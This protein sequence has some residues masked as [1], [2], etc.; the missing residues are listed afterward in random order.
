MSINDQEFQ[1]RFEGLSVAEAGRKVKELRSDGAV[2]DVVP[3]TRTRVVP[4]S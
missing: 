3:N 4:R 1:I 2:I